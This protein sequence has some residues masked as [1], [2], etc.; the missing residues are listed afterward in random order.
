M[1]TVIAPPFTDP[2][3]AAQKVQLAENLWNTRDPERVA[4]AYTEDTQWRNRIEF[5][6]GRAAVIEFLTRKWQRELDYKLKKE[7]WG[8]RDNRM[9]VKFQYEWHDTQG[10]WYRSYG[11]ELWE[12]APSGLMRRREASINDLAIAEADRIL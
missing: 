8:F 12:F 5:L 2:D 11:N 4:A 9:A 1:S 7:L 3:H 6:T 10:Q